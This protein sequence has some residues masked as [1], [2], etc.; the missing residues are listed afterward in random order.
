M[1][2]ELALFLKRQGK[3]RLAANGRSPWQKLQRRHGAREAAINCVATH[4]LG[5]RQILHNLSNNHRVD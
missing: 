4:P 5:E 2:T 1:N 3:A